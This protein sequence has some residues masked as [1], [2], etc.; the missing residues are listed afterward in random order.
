M[1]QKTQDSRLDV[2]RLESL[3]ESARVLGSSLDMEDQLNHLMRTVMGRLLVTKGLIALSDNGVLRVAAARGLRGVSAGD[4]L[5]AGRLQELGLTITFDIGQAPES[6]GILAIPTPRRPGWEGDGHE[7]EFLDALLS[8]ASTTIDKARAHAEALRTNRALAQKVQELRTLIDVARGVSST[9]DPEE[10]ASILLL[11]VSG[12]WAVRQ[13]A[14]LTWAPDHP[15]LARAKGIPGA[16]LERWARLMKDAAQPL[17]DGDFVLFPLLDGETPT[18]LVA[19]GPPAIGTGYTE[20]DI[21]FCSA[22][23]A[24]ASVALVNAW[25]VQDTLYRRE[26]EKELELAASIQRDLFPKE[27]PRVPGLDL[28]AAN[29][30]ARQVG[31]DYY[32]VLGPAAAPVLCVADISGKG[33]GASLLMASLQ[34]TLRALLDAR[35][36]LTAL[37]GRTNALLYASTPDNRYA[38]LFL[39][40]CGAAAGA[41]EY[42]NAAHSTGLLVR[43]GGEVEP[44]ESTGL[45]VG[46][47]ENAAYESGRFQM[48]PGDA[49]VLYSDGVTDA[50]AP[51][52]EEFGL[53]RVIE[54]VRGCAGMEAGRICAAL[55]D[56]IAAFVEDTPQYDDITVLVARRTP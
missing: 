20:D 25:R 12:R 41:C 30:Q 11:T 4:L 7:R 3:L 17:R 51:T 55:L 23:V 44:L 27:L 53:E 18:G 46:L 47:F 43:A 37:A 16:E 9:I 35:P 26:L 14:L 48:R 50:L 5:D 40:R 31:G 1:E 42:V 36:D 34:A 24:Q 2:S 54:C 39:V 13:H 29:R 56:A 8:L 10:V 38:T 49:L 45:P 33:I 22:L 19:L 15:A 21:E 32:D 28:A 6:L 52:G